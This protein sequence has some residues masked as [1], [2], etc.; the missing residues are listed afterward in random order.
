M[1]TGSVTPDRQARV[2][3]SVCDSGGQPQQ[4]D[5]VLDTGFTGSLALPS[6]RCASLGL[7]LSGARPAVLADGSRVQLPVY[8]ATVLWDGRR[9]SILALGTGGTALI[10]MSL[11]YGSLVTLEIVDGGQVTIDALP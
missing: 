6:A 9:R 4:T 3:L 2:V 10:G 7:R 5:V 8:R 11:L 1:I